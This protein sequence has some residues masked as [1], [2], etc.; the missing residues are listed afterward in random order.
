VKFTINLHRHRDSV[1]KRWDSR[2]NKNRCNKELKMKTK[3]VI[4]T[5]IALA[6]AVI[7][8]VVAAQEGRPHRGGRGGFDTLHDLAAIVTDA[9][10][11][12][13]PE[14]RE[15]VAAGATL[16]EVIEAN[17]GNVADVLAQALTVIEERVAQA[18]AD[19]NISAERAALMLEN[20]EQ[21]L[22]D[23]LNGEGRIMAGGRMGHWG[24]ARPLVQAVADATGLEAQ[25]IVE[26]VQ[27]GSTLANI[28]TA[29]GVD[30]DTFVADHTAQYT[31][32]LNALVEN[33]RISQAVADAR[34]NLFNVELLDR[35]HRVVETATE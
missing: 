14:I 3:A 6:L 16:A 32:R 12:T 30:V 4:L 5:V 25:A 23:I 20:L 1:T 18:Q 10:G 21:H 19:G 34:L 9:T 28:L 33:G 13:M 29:N 8:G 22:T 7:V 24:A 17:G 35:L 2:S 27:A 15:Q 11:L 26:Q 31:E